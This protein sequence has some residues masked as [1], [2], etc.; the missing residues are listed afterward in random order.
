MLLMLIVAC[1]SYVHAEDFD[2]LDIFCDSEEEAMSEDYIEGGASGSS[3]KLEAQLMSD[4]K[5][6][7]DLTY[8]ENSTYILENLDVGGGESRGQS[9]PTGGIE[10]I[11]GE[12]NWS[13]RIEGPT[14]CI[15]DVEF[16]I[17]AGKT[18]QMCVPLYCNE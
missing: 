2:R 11:R 10:T 17:K 18:L 8:I 5:Y 12:G 15:G 1:K 3:G 13:M 16:E 4:A 7:R 6:A 14:G 9:D